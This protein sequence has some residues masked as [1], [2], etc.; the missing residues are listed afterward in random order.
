M[1]FSVKINSLSPKFYDNFLQIAK[2]KGK[3]SHKTEHL[4][5]FKGYNQYNYKISEKIYVSFVKTL[6]N[7]TKQMVYYVGFHYK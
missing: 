5:E 2:E 4:K 6:D 3:F 1:K 7:E